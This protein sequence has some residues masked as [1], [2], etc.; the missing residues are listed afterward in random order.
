V[1]GDNS[2]D[3]HN[4]TEAVGTRLTPQTKRQF[5]QYRDGNEL[6]NSEALRRIVRSGLQAEMEKDPIEQLQASQQ[7]AQRRQSALLV[8]G[9]AYIAISV[10][11]GISALWWGVM[12]TVIFCF[13]IYFTFN[14]GT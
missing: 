5:E 9:L 3:R 7:A 11:T 10:L 6:S 1:T 12:G 13:L 2:E 4:Y 14:I 8:V